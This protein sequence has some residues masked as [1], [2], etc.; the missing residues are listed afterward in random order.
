MNRNGFSRPG[1]R[2]GALGQG[3]VRNLGRSLRPDWLRTWLAFAVGIA[4]GSGAGLPM[5]ARAD[6][7]PRKTGKPAVGGAAATVH[8][9]ATEAAIRALEEGGNAVDAAVSAALM[10]GVVDGQNSGIGGGCLALVRLANG[11]FVALDGRETA[12][13]AATRDMFVRDGKAVPELSQAGALAVGVPGELAALDWLSRRHGR[14]PLRRALLEA[15]RVAEEGFVVTPAY[16]RRLMD[17]A[18]K[19]RKFPGAAA[20]FLHADGTPYAAG[21]TLRQPELAATYRILAERGVRWFYRGGFAEATAAWMR[22]NGGLIT[23]ADFGRY[24][25]KAREAV[26]SRYRDC[27]IVGFPPPS[28]GGVHVAQILNIL[29]RF[30]LRSMGD[31]SVDFAHVTAEALG[32]AFADRAH[33]LGDSDFTAVPRGIAA[34][35]YGEELAGEIRMDRTT[36]VQGPGIPPRA[37]TDLFGKHTTHLTTV[38]AE[39]NWV[40]LTATVNTTFGSKVVVPGTGVVLN[41]E[42]D[43]FSA[44]PGQTNFFGLLGSEANAVAPGKRPLSSMSP[45][46]VLREGRPVFTVGAAGGPTIISQA[47]LAIVRFVDFGKDP[48]E[49]LSAPRLHHQWRPREV[50]L[51][52]GWDAG[53]AQGLESR[54]HR[55]RQVR[56][57]GAAQAI[58]WDGRTFQPAADPRV[59]GSA[60]VTP[61]P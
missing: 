7:A 16:A 21:E 22:A 48:V 8:P 47:V 18:A 49:A 20:L 19:V 12:P 38:D 46:V 34:A 14:L 39:G 4:L 54:G 52:A 50:V 40:A 59:D 5:S 55:V 35:S 42:M 41:N 15:A 25:V 60:Q 57:L 61:R 56:S 3:G 33:W 30:D 51:E 29:G 27:E 24:R 37:W 53:V 31:G 9:R 17:E 28:S 44:Q 10:L 58:G 1:R 36:E 43:D 6:S 23:K 45:T 2:E 32:R 11:R 26:R 13:A